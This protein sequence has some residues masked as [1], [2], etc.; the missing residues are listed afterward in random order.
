MTCPDCDRPQF[1][2]KCQCGYVFRKTIV[3]VSPKWTPE[4]PEDSATEAFNVMRGALHNRYKNADC[5]PQIMADGL[6]E[7]ISV[8]ENAEWSRGEV[9]GNC[10]KHRQPHTLYQCLCDE[11]E[12]WILRANGAT[13]AEANMKVLG[14][15]ALLV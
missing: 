8:K 13:A 11:L 5:N 12:Y 15:A 2:D 14:H 1:A 10:G 9:M 7:W 6:A 3:T 4:E